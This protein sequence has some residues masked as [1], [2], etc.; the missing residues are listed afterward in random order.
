MRGKRNSSKKLDEKAGG[1]WACTCLILTCC[2][3][4]VIIIHIP[5]QGGLFEKWDC[6]S[7]H[8]A[9]HRLTFTNVHTLVLETGWGSKA[10]AVSPFLSLSPSRRLTRFTPPHPFS[11]LF[12]FFFFFHHFFSP[13]KSDPARLLSVTRVIS[14]CYFIWLSNE[15]NPIAFHSNAAQIMRGLPHPP[16]LTLSLPTLLLMDEGKEMCD[17]ACV[18]MWSVQSLQVFCASFPPL[19]AAQRNLIV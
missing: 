5:P 19:W 15:S 7:P 8:P 11:F 14:L 9:C 12:S 10:M 2:T 6:I 18:S 3:A 13:T 16:V 1:K 4:A 17:T